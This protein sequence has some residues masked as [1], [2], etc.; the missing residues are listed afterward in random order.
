M[1]NLI[2]CRPE[3]FGRYKDR[4]LASLQQLG[5][6]HIEIQVPAPDQVQSVAQELKSY[7]LQ[8]ASIGFYDKVQNADFLDKLKEAVDAATTLGAS[9]IFTSQHAGETERKKIYETLRQAGDIAKAKNITIAL[10]THPD[11]CQNATVAL[12]TM[13]S[14]EHPNIRINFDPANVHYY[15]ENVNAVNELHQI[16]PYVRAVHLKDT[17]GGFKTWH[18]PAIGEGVVDWP[19]VFSIMNQQGMYGPFTMEMEGIEGEDLSFEE[20]YARIEKSLDYLR[21][22]G[23]I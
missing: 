14:T 5:F 21:S 2:S 10:E 17:N 8:A 11:L 18:F 7:G 13:H 4:A 22:N 15:N 3:S 16:A 12:E 6:E 20:T 9:V 23:L 1:K 19:E